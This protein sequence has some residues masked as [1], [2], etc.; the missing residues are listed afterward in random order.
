MFLFFLLYIYIYILLNQLQRFLYRRK[1]SLLLCLI[2]LYVKLIY[3]SIFK[4]I[5]NV[6]ILFFHH[7]YAYYNF[8]HE[9]IIL[10]FLKIY[11]LCQFT[12]ILKII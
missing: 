8:V 2:M 11:L 10:H 3:T 1:S 7:L 4:N 9:I 5:Y 6:K 12:I